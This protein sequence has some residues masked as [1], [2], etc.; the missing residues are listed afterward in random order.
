[1]SQ[2]LILQLQLDFM[3]LQFL[4]EPLRVGSCFDARPFFRLPTQPGFSKATQLADAR[5]DVG[6][7]FYFSVSPS[8]P[9]A[10]RIVSRLDLRTGVLAS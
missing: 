3:D 2:L 5:R 7:L 1:L 8:A 10:F 9:A 4:Q 6:S